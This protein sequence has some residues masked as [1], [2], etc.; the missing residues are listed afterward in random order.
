MNKKITAIALSAT[1]VVW[2]TGASAFVPVAFAQST[3]EEIASL[4]ALIQQLTSQLSAL[5]G[6]STAAPVVTAPVV[7]S[8]A[9]SFTRNLTVGSQGA[10]VKCLQQYLNGAGFT[11]AS[12]GAGSPGN[13]TTYFGPIT[14]AAA[15]KWQDAYAAEVLAPVGLSK[16]TGFWGPSSRSY[17]SSLVAVAPV[18]TVPGTTTPVSPAPTV[19]TGQAAG[20]LVVGLASD[21]PAG[22]NI[23]KGASSVEFMKFVVTGSGTLD[24]LKFARTGLGQTTD[25]VSGGVYLYKGSTRLTT[26]KSVN[27]TTHEVQFVSLKEDVSGSETYTLVADIASGATAGNLSGFKLVTVNSEDLT[28]PIQGEEMAV[29]GVSVGT[30]TAAKNG[31]V[32]S[33]NVGSVGAKLS[34]F[35]LTTNSTEDQL[36]RRVVLTHGGSV[37]VGYLTNLELRQAGVLLAKTDGYVGRDQYVLELDEPFKILKGQDRVFEVYGDV[38][39]LAKVSETIKLYLDNNSDVLV[40]GNTYGWGVT[41]TITTFDSGS[42]DHHVLTLLGADILLTFHGPQARDIPAKAQDLTLFDFSISSKSNIEIRTITFTNTIAHTLD[43]DQGFNDWKVVDAET[44]A[45]VTSSEDITATGDTALTDVINVSA[46]SVRRFLVT[47]DVDPDNDADDT[48]KVTLKAFGT[49]DI[50]NL[51][52][53]TYVTPSSD[54]VPNAAI[55]GNTQTVKTVSLDVLASGIPASHTAVAGSSN[56]DLLGLAITARNGDVKITSMKITASAS[57][58]TEAQVRNDVR[59]VG[60]YVDDQLISTKESLADDSTVSSATF[61]NLS[62]VIPEGEVKN[63]LIKADNI[64]TDATSANQYFIYLDQANITAVDEEGNSLSLTGE[65]NGALAT[66]GTIRVTIG[67]PTIMAIMITDQESEAGNVIAGR[68]QLLAKYNFFA[69]NAAQTVTKLKVGV[70]TAASVATTA[71]LAQEVAQIRLYDGVSGAL[72]A[73][74]SPESSGDYAGAVRFEDIG[75]IFTVG[76][77]EIKRIEVRALL[78]TI[79]PLGSGSAVSSLAAYVGGGQFESVSGAASNTTLKDS[80]ETDISTTSTDGVV[81]SLKRM[82]KSVPTVTVSSPGSS[83]LTTGQVELLK[84]TVAAD[85]AGDVEWN[86]LE[87][88]SSLSNATFTV[89]TNDSQTIDVRYNGSDLTLSTATLAVGGGEGVIKVTTPELIAAGTSKTYSL[90]ATIGE[91]AGSTTAASVST[92]MDGDATGYVAAGTNAVNTAT[93]TNSFVWSDLSRQPHS[94]ASSDWHNDWKVKVLPSG[95]KALVK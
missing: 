46:G 57:P 81:G 29:S 19:G 23:P 51:D 48:I 75:G 28:S 24:S 91:M 68:E 59:T 3:A 35:K 10:D 50:K 27:S 93:A 73:A 49:S 32:A 71:A 11:L 31:S 78:N 69:K 83:T 12:S 5:Q 54:I 80:G 7:S 1:T 86:K 82:Y 58:G 2:L 84:F 41:P 39:P 62:L 9:C 40:T 66:A 34:E 61:S 67:S 17:Y 85:S 8:G 55:A 22:A 88:T 13:E 89:S 25:F 95:A 45:A 70:N 92:V 18:V 72:L 21:S 33:P 38:S 43:S 60:L 52:N 15:V 14:R 76:A 26:G 42:S 79:D 30:I 56:E 4:Q 65:I 36:V 63:V 20:S 94:T 90:M 47:A 87:F 6:T 77:N 64:A 53:N 37:N 44:G 16:G 74:G